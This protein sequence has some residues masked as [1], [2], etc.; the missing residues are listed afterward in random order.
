MDRFVK[1]VTDKLATIDGEGA[2]HE[3]TVVSLFALIRQHLEANHL[4]SQYK[5]TA[6]YCD[7]CLHFMLDRSP[8]LE[9]FFRQIDDAISDDKETLIND[10]INEIISLKQLRYELI[11]IIGPAGANSNLFGSRGGW[12]AFIQVFLKSLVDKP[13]VRNKPPTAKRL[14]GHFMLE[15]PDVSN[16]DKDYI[17]QNAIPLGAVFWKVLVLP[18]GYTLT[19]PLVN[20][21]D[22]A[23]FARD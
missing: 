13:I 1:Q 20:I 9:Y 7:W 8:V 10:R 12:K 23:N 4:K 15:I 3:D 16:L 6:F 14:A 11:Q 19:G 2:F 5:V 18:I 17:T 21:E 22:P